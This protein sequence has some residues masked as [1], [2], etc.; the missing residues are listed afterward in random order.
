MW[1]TEIFPA[2]RRPIT[3]EGE[4]RVRVTAGF[5]DEASEENRQSDRL[6]RLLEWSIVVV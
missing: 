3:E 2:S 1:E 5:S 6:T 4:T